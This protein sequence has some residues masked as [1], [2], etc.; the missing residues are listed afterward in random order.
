M[1]P[2]K[3]E[4]R[5]GLCRL[6]GAMVRIGRAGRFIKHDLPDG[7]DRCKGS[8]QSAGIAPARPPRLRL[9]DFRRGDAIDYRQRSTDGLDGDPLWER[10]TVHKTTATRIWI[11][12]GYGGLI[13][14]EPSHR[15]VRKVYVDVPVATGQDQVRVMFH[16]EAPPEPAD[17]IDGASYARVPG[18]DALRTALIRL[19]WCSVADHDDHDASC[20]AGDPAPLCEAWRALKFGDHWPGYKH[21]EVRLAASDALRF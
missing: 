9:I 13:A 18:P 17:T 1:G 12:T 2:S 14:I 16:R 3:R 20:T 19:L 7:G 5:S 10:G 11:R 15:R 21:A 4:P 8:D 6:C